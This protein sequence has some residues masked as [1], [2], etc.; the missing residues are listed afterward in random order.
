MPAVPSHA[1]RRLLAA[2]TLLLAAGNT[3]L[4]RENSAGPPAE[5]AAPHAAQDDRLAWFRDARFGMFV[6]WSPDSE[7]AGEWNGQRIK[8]GHNAAWI[9][10]LLNIPA[11]EYRAMA[12]QFKPEKFDAKAV[13]RPAKAAGQLLFARSPNP[14][15]A[16]YAHQP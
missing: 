1:T 14:T 13:V 4:A 8:V 6:H 10:H 11:P 15:L 12:R 3:C 7:L 2:V 5:A 16:P 9:M